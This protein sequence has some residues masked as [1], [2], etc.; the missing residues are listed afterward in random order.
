MTVPDYLCQDYHTGIL[1]GKCKEGY[2]KVIGSDECY[3]CS[4]ISYLYILL[5]ILLGV[6]L[7]IALFLCKLTVSDTLFGSVIFYASMTEISLR[8]EALNN[9]HQILNSFMSFLNISLGFRLCIY[10]GLTSLTKT[11]FLFIY[12]IYLWLIVILLTIAS[13]KS[14]RLSNLISRSAVQVLAT[15]F[16]L[17]FSKLISVTMH[18]FLYAT[19]QTPEGN[20]LVWYEDG[21]VLYLKN[22]WH[23]GLMCVAT[24]M[25]LV[26]VLPFLF[27]TTFAS[28]GLKIRCL[29]IRQ[30][31]IDAYH[32]Q[33]RDKCGWLFGIKMWILLI[34]NI[35]YSVL[36]SKN[37]TILFVIYIALLFPLTYVYVYFK[38]YRKEWFNFAES[39]LLHNLL[40]VE[41]VLLYNDMKGDITQSM[42]YITLL[43]Y[44]A[45]I[46][47]FGSIVSSHMLKSKIGQRFVEF[48]NRHLQ[49]LK[50][51]LA[52]KKAAKDVPIERSSSCEDFR[53][54]LLDVAY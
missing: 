41:L 46:V 17:S 34:A 52:S 13:K 48:L 31:L 26:Y 36:R 21:N 35:A 1:C 18:V 40:F 14:T 5:I 20:M 19:V 12:P 7:V 54:P 15:L 43:M 10:N 2:S 50:Q 3:K 16:C 25:T 47:L 39:I 27:W 42:T 23:I 33:Y 11:A 29:R 6:G 9:H 24:L 32:G 4:D 45:L 38:P 51:F 53:E 37:T 22:K 49:L 30:N 8:R 28:F 44:F